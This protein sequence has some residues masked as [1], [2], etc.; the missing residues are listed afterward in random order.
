M[1]LYELKEGWV[2]QSGMRNF[3]DNTIKIALLELDDTMKVGGTDGVYRNE[4]SSNE[5]TVEC[6][7]RKLPTTV[8]ATALRMLLRGKDK[9]QA[10]DLHEDSTG[11]SYASAVELTNG[12]ESRVEAIERNQ[13]GALM[14]KHQDQDQYSSMSVE[15]L[16]KSVKKS[17]TK[18]S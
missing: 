16:K 12:M 7:N 15:E 3:D 6:S 1:T 2:N 5:L 10:L 11:E 4:F 8:S 9:G 14:L 18:I 13:Q 17:S